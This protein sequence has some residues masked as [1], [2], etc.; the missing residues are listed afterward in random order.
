LHLH[1]TLSPSLFFFTSL[2][3]HSWF[4]FF[5]CCKLFLYVLNLLQC[6]T[7]SFF[8]TSHFLF[9]CNNATICFSTFATTFFHLH[10]FVLQDIFFFI[11][12]LKKLILFFVSL[13]CFLV[14]RNCVSPFLFCGRSHDDFILLHLCWCWTN[15][16]SILNI[17]IWLHGALPL[18]YTL[19]KH[20]YKKIGTSKFLYK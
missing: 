1:S 7:M 19:M 4:I 10:S 16:S 13:I 18:H 5:H 12:F 8:V 15:F 9:V 14:C 3:L 6:R 11:L 2:L 17:H 20:F